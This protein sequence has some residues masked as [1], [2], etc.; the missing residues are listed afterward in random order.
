MWSSPAAITWLVGVCIH[1][2]IECCA[3]GDVYNSIAAPIK[4]FF[5]PKAKIL[6][7]Q[8]LVLPISYQ[9]LCQPL[10]G[11]IIKLFPELEPK[12]DP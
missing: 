11:V 8:L 12:I 3:R 1:K 10:I 7:P 9:I 2:K 6:A 4:R 5:T